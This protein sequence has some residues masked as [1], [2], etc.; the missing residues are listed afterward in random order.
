MHNPPSSFPGAEGFGA[1][2][3]GGRGGQVLTVTTLAPSGEGSLQAALDTPGARTI[4]FAVSGVIDTT[5]NITHGN[6][7]IAGQTSPG[8]SSCVGWCVTVIT[9]GTTVAISS[10]AMCARALLPTWEGV[11]G[12][13]MMPCAWMGYKMPSSTIVLLPTPAM[14][15]YKSP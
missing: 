8:E 6:V 12:F 1:V 14:R 3:S 5:A 11:A 4:V 2:A 7:T 13:W 15:R 10:C 9:R